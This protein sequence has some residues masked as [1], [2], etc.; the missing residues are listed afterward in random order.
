M[1]AIQELGKLAPAT[2]LLV[3]MD[4]GGGVLNEREVAIALV[5]RGDI[6]KVFPP[7]P[8]GFT[9]HGFLSV[10]NSNKSGYASISPCAKVGVG[11]MQGRGWLRLWLSNRPEMI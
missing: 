8:Q 7:P 5:Q 1:Q 9:A 10:F 3:T 4:A 11:P 6:L 2:A